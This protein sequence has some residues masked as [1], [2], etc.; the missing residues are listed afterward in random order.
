MSVLTKAVRDI[1]FP[2]SWILGI[3]YEQYLGW[4]IHKKNYDLLFDPEL[5]VFHI[6][7]GQTLSRHITDKKRK[8]LSILEFN[9]EFYRLYGSEENLSLKHRVLWII[10]N[11]LN[12]LKKI[13]FDKQID[14]TIYIRALFY[15]EI[16]G[17]KWILSKKFRGTYSPIHDLEKI[18]R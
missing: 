14:R 16:I 13:C 2:N 12:N 10:F 3:T 4:Y 1:T 7:H 18:L 6:I 5:K 9:L 15:S 8:Y 11:I 17:L